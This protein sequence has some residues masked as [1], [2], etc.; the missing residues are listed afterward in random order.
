MASRFRRRLMYFASPFASTKAMAGIM[1]KLIS[2]VG[3]LGRTD[4]ALAVSLQFV[5][6]GIAWIIFSDSAMLMLGSEN[7]LGQLTHIHI[8]KGLLFVGVTGAF[9]FY[10]V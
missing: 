5:V 4:P 6:F 10:F 8:L 9:I 1:K 3:F 2:I 7:I